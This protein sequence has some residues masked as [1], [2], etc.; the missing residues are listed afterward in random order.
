M[1][2]YSGTIPSMSIYQEV[3]KDIYQVRLPLPFRL[4]HVQCYLL[5]GESGWTI[6]DAGLNMS[7]SRNGWLNSFAAL[8]IAPGDVTQIV[9]THT[10]PDHYGLAGW[11]Q[12]WHSSRDFVPPVLLSQ[13]EAIFADV[14]WVN[15]E[16][17][18]V[19]MEQTFGRCGIEPE[20]ARKIAAEVHRVA[21]RTDP[22]P[23]KIQTL[24]AG[25]MIEMGNRTFQIIHT[26][27]HADGHL[28]FYDKADRLLLSG[29]HVLNSI[30]PHIGRWPKGDADPLGRY[31][32]SLRSL[33]QLDVQLALPGHKALIRNWH[34]RLA[35]LQIHHAERLERTVTAVKNFATVSDIATQ[36]F[37]L[38]A[39]DMHNTRF[40]LAETL[41]HLDLLVNQG[42]LVC[43][44]EHDI[45]HYS[46]A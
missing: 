11:L 28:I 31:L 5:R 36:E 19:S 37:N 22:H 35:E 33:K 45:W 21:S 18:I 38:A 43:H 24:Q 6:V 40:A 46:P 41:A 9:L 17:L 20:Q 3:A 12:A 42:R 25:S 13:R 44:N 1:T 8:G 32:D 4:D 26:P 30:T 7:V 15:F 27:G 23:T 34:G 10:H 39:L 29:D 2:Q 14:C 16:T